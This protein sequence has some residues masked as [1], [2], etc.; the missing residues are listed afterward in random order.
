MNAINRRDLLAS[1]LAA[2]S[3]LLPLGARAQSKYPDRPIRFIVPFPP[4]G[5]YDYIGRPWAERIK[6]YIGNTIVV[7]NM[8]GAGGGVGAA[9]ATRQRPDG[10]TLLLG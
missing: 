3:A 6:P 5:A 1:G 7:E 10:Y 9:F 8:R 4:G 2:A